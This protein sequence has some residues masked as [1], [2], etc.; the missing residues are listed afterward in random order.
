MAERATAPWVQAGTEAVPT[1]LALD[2][3]RREHLERAEEALRRATAIPAAPIE[4]FVRHAFVLHRVGR[5]LEAKERLGSIPADSMAADT[6][7]QYWHGLIAG[8][9]HEALDD[10]PAAERAYTSAIRA[11]GGAQTA[12]I[13]L[14][15]L[16][17]RQGRSGEAERWI[18]TVRRLPA[19]AADPWW[20]YWFGDERWIETWLREMRQLRP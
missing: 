16:L 1:L 8:R 19:D 6:A 7:L 13:A 9:I 17:E 2:G 3:P 15:S 4:G 10:I 11:S 18:A 14:G 20:N 12:A 5:N